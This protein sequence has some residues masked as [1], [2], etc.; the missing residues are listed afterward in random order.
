V[1]GMRH[2]GTLIAAV[3]VGPLAW[4]LIAFGQD[5]SAQVF[6]DAR[7]S[8]TLRTED[9]VAPLVFLAGAGL[10]LGLIGTLRFSPL[11]ATVIGIV[12]TSS[13]SMLLVA[14]KG[15]LDLLTN[16]LSVAGRHADL[17]TPIRTGTTMVLGAMLLVAGLSIGR[18]RRW[19]K[20][21]TADEAAADDFGTAILGE[22]TD[23]DLAVRYATR[24]DP[25]EASDYIPYRSASAQSTSDYYRW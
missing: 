10:L 22:R 7:L 12:Y 4:I 20:P 16:D 2:I 23:P 24:P 17:T 1:R 18:W 9:F 8:G 25:R 21:S 11:G 5:R 13:Y 14:P 6:T 15:T 3:V 19:P